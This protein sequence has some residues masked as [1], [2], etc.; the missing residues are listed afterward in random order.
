[1]V[2]QRMS[3]WVITESLRGKSITRWKNQDED[4]RAERILCIINK[5]ARRMIECIFIGVPCI[6][7]TWR[8][9]Y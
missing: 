5:L 7:D 3:G 8:G 9:G 1:M 2:V 6:K 4:S